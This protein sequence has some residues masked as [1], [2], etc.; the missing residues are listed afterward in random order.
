LKENQHARGTAKPNGGTC[1][2]TS[3]GAQLMDIPL[4]LDD[5]VAVAILGERAASELR[6]KTATDEIDSRGPCGP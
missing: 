3:R 1:R 5:P 6:K 4:V 2:N